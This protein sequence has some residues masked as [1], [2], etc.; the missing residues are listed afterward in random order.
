MDPGDITVGYSANPILA[1]G[2]STSTISVTAN[3]SNGNPVADGTV[4]SFMTSNGTLSAPTAQTVGGVATVEITSSLVVDPSVDI[5]VTVDGE[6]VVDSSLA[7]T[8]PDI[9]VVF[10]TVVLAVNPFL[11][12]YLWKPRI[13][14]VIDFYY[15]RC[16]WRVF[17]E[18]YICIV[19][20]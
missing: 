14:V 1:N 5:T 11:V 7:F 10:W 20:V 9:L 18:S 13:I 16:I 12:Q 8:F 19:C 17:Y 6:T 2:T 4:V 15:Y 3:D